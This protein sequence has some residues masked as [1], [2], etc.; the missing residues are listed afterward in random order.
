MVGYR[1]VSG[2]MAFLCPRLL[3]Y[4]LASVSCQF[5]DSVFLSIGI[6]WWELNVINE[7]LLIFAVKEILLE[8]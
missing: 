3:L 8:W 7:K 6:N 4:F 1:R 5:C 2:F